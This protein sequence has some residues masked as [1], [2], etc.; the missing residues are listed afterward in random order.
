MNEYLYID[1]FTRIE[2]LRANVRPVANSRVL[3]GLRNAL[4]HNRLDKTTK[5]QGPEYNAKEAIPA[6]KTA[7]IT[8]QYSL[9]HGVEQTVSHR[10]K[11]IFANHF[12]K[13]SC[14][15]KIPRR[16][17]DAE[18][19]I[20]QASECSRISISRKIFVKIFYF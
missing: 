13:L 12:R 2:Y 16:R 5:Q 8:P 10:H 19:T 6:C 9:F 1:I 15:D 7:H 20:L 3:R 18:S 11:G 4:S 14:A 17:D